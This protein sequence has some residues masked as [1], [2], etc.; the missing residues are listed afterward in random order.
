MTEEAIDLTADAALDTAD[1]T[2]LVVLDMDEDTLLAVETTVLTAL[3]ALDTDLD[4]CDTDGAAMETASTSLLVVVL[5][6]DVF[7]LVLLLED[8]LLDE[9]PPEEPPPEELDE[10]GPANSVLCLSLSFTSQCVHTPCGLISISPIEASTIIK[11]HG[12]SFVLP[13]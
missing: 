2:A 10:D 8:E 4:A 13:V 7:V 5:S 11:L 6:A 1:V 9:P 12:N 3:I